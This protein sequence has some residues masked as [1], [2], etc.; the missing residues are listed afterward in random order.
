MRIPGHGHLDGVLVRAAGECGQ[1]FG[2]A[3]HPTARGGERP[4]HRHRGLRERPEFAVDHGGVP[5]QGHHRT[6][7]P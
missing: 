5:A 2:A 4:Q 1:Q 6:A 3:E 7:D